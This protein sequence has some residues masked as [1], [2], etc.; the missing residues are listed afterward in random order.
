VVESQEDEDEAAEVNAVQGGRQRGN[1][2]RGGQR[3][4]SRG[5]AAR[6]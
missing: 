3:A 4:S 2:R 6:R 1:G 5:P